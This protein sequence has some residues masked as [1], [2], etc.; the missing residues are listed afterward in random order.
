M[1]L[2]TREQS[3][4][5]SPTA[6]GCVP[7]DHLESVLFSHL[8]S[9]GSARVE[10]GTTLER[11]ESRADGVQALVRG[12]D[13][14]SRDVHARYLV[15]ADG[16]YSTVRDQLEIRMHGSQDILAAATALF[17]APLWPLLTEHRYG[18]YSIGLPKP[19]ACSSPP[20]RAT[21]GVTG[22]SSRPA[23]AADGEPSAEQMTERIRLAAG[24]AD[25]P[26]RLERL[27]SFSSAAQ[28]AERF[29]QD[30]VFLVGDAA[31]RVT[32]RGGTGMNTAIQDGH[33]LGWKL[34]WVLRG[35]AHPDLLEL[36]RA[37]APPGRR[38]Q[39]RPLGRP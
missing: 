7:Q 38:A 18:I 30:N 5:I 35:W 9:L 37:R 12:S 11:I 14:A 22:S 15:A 32:P 6:P 16:A 28:L 1:G 4:L 36:L 39:C 27:G 24:V 13:G 23:T 20:A 31:H 17:R 25:L 3:A 26:L 34:A 19:R 10:L 29:R 8:R 2:P 33:D 21:A